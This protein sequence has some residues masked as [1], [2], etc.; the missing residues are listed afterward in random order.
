M[1]GISSTAP[2]C[3]SK[4]KGISCCISLSSGL[5]FAW[6][7]ERLYV[8]FL[9]LLFRVKQIRVPLSSCAWCRSCAGWEQSEIGK[10]SAC[11][12]RVVA[13][14]KRFSCLL[15]IFLVYRISSYCNTADLFVRFFACLTVA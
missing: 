2:F 5:R 15:V 10:L 3:E 4:N 6:C 7:I 1:P 14:V 11:V 9:P 8:S 12:F 13:V